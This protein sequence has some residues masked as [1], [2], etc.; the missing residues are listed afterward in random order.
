MQ[1]ANMLV[2][3]RGTEALRD[4]EVATALRLSDTQQVRIQNVYRRNMASLRHRLREL[5]QRCGRRS[6]VRDTL[7][8]FQS[9]SGAQ[10]VSLLSP[11]QQQQFE[12]MRSDSGR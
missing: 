8:E 7:R 1:L 4:P 10:I 9:Q 11:E 3:L 6:S 2:R 5:L 12:N